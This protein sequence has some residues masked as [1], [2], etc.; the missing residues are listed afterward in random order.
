MVVSNPNEGFRRLYDAQCLTIILSDMILGILAFFVLVESDTKFDARDV[1]VLSPTAVLYTT[2]FFNG[3]LQ[4]L[5]QT[6]L[7]GT[8]LFLNF[9]R[10]AVEEHIR[11]FFRLIVQE[12]W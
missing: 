7:N 8:I 1:S 5:I 3:I 9:L 2:A 6:T 10:R 12:R 4:R 11:Q